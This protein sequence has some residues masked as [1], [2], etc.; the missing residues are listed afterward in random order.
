MSQGERRIDSV[1]LGAR[2]CEVGGSEGG[3][4]EQE[5][6]GQRAPSTEGEEGQRTQRGVG[7]V[8]R[9]AIGGVHHEAHDM[10]IVE[11]LEPVRA[12]F[13]GTCSASAS[14]RSLARRSGLRKKKS[15]GKKVHQIGP[16]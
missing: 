2:Q 10:T 6:K 1:N 12:A 7:V 3:E 8:E 4:K 13:G 15:E 14:A 11:V 9:L 5:T 16:P